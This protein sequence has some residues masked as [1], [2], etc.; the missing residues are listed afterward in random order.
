MY[1]VC[2]SIS[3][4]L[5]SY[6]NTEDEEKDRRKEEKNEGKGTGEERTTKRI[7]K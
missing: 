3:Y 7:K 2:V 4:F 6:V 5:L 1:I